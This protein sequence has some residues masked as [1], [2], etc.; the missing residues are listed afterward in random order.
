MAT[1]VGIVS[2]QVF[3]LQYVLQNMNRGISIYEVDRNG[4]LAMRTPPTQAQLEQCNRGTLIDLAVRGGMLQVQ[5]ATKVVLARFVEDN[6]RN[7]TIEMTPSHFGVRLCNVFSD[8][9]VNAVVGVGPPP[10]PP[11]NHYDDS[12]DGSSSTADSMLQQI[13]E[14][15]AYDG[16]PHRQPDLPS[17]WRTPD[18]VGTSEVLGE[19]VGSEFVPDTASEYEEVKNNITDNKKIQDKLKEYATMT[20]SCSHDE[21]KV[22]VKVGETTFPFFYKK[23]TSG[24]DLVDFLDFRTDGKLN[25][26]SVLLCLNGSNP[27]LYENLMSYLNPDDVLVI[28]PRVRGGG[29]GMVKKTFLKSKQEAVE[30]LKSGM[31]KSFS[32]KTEDDVPNNQLTEEFVAV[33][34]NI[35]VKFS[36]FLALKNRCGGHFIEM[37]LRQVN[38]SDLQ[39]L[40]KMFSTNRRGTGKNLT[41]EE[42]MQ[43][44]LEMLFPS[45]KMI[46]NY[47]KKLNFVRQDIIATLM[48]C[49]AE[50]FSIFNESAGSV[51]L[52]GNSFYNKI[53][54]QTDMTI[55]TVE[56]M[57]RHSC[58]HQILINNGWVQNPQIDENTDGLPFYI[59]KAETEHILFKSFYN[60]KRMRLSKNAWI[61][62]KREWGLLME[63]VQRPFI[64]HM[65]EFK[66]TVFDVAMWAYGLPILVIYDKNN[67]HWQPDLEFFHIELSMRGNKKVEDITSQ[68]ISDAFWEKYRLRFEAN[69][70]RQRELHFRTV[71]VED[72]VMLNSANNPNHIDWGLERLGEH[73]RRDEGIYI[74][75]GRDPDIEVDNEDFE[76]FKLLTHPIELCLFQ[77]LDSDGWSSDEGEEQEDDE[78]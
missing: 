1:V 31:E 23:D 71:E 20:R 56:Y 7:I 55:K 48:K 54:T 35:N 59:D 42:K 34:N 29:R 40:E 19:K 3:G 78:D 75:E 73:L 26:D 21:V 61:C 37:G 44:T 28:V 25:H 27:P 41:V 57:E 76:P 10:N 12:D 9:F 13:L 8:A 6:W 68:D 52:D 38:I 4:M 72:T 45:L 63:N 2:H 50:E 24:N 14:G 46:D 62:I 58:I 16:Q 64:G 22:D 77:H 65:D 49:F 66:N 43:R 36:D 51:N 74:Y 15:D 33:I 60:L 47:E 18:S 70:W 30:H 17:G 53:A 39:V 11:L 5:R 67:R 32:P 69:N